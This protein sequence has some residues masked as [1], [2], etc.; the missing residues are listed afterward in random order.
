MKKIL[1]IIISLTLLLAGC[2]KKE[3]NNSNQEKVSSEIEYFSSQIAILLNNLNNISLDNYELVSEKINLDKS[4][5][6]SKNSN[7]EDSQNNQVLNNEGEENV[8]VTDIKTKNVLNLDTNNID[9]NLMKNQIELI[10]SSWSIVMLD[11]S[12]TNVPE[13]EINGFSS[14]LDKTIISIKN[15]NKPEALKNLTELYSYIPKFLAKTSTE[16]GKLNIE[17]TKYSIFKA[18]SDISQDDWNTVSQ[19][20]SDA[21]TYF[22]NVLN[23]AE[24]HGNK[25][26]KIDKVYILIQDIQTVTSSKDKELFLVKYKTLM[27]S[28]NTL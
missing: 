22:K 27:E 10:N 18:Y 19:N 12:K 23:D 21:E 24:A 8:F 9:W 7:S 3:E 15:E 13:S 17:K 25:D 16:K 6:E 4:E 5:T 11:L 26:F 1:V 28:L 14:L 20:L 2:A